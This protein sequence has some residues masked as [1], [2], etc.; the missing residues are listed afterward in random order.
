MEGVTY[1]KKEIFF[2]IEP[3]LF[4]LWTITL[5][6]RKIFNATI[7]GV[8]VKTKDPMFNFPHLKG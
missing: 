2:I 5:L 4:T 1:E 6:E 7:F 8:A 3:N